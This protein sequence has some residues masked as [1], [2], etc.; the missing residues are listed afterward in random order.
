MRKRRIAAWTVGL[1]ALG[2]AMLIAT[3]LSEAVRDPVERSTSIALPGLPRQGAPYRIALLSDIHIGNRAMRP[4]RLERIVDQ[5]NAV[6]PDLVVLAGDFVNG[7]S[8]KLDSDPRALTAPLSRLR[9]SDGVI[10]TPGNHDHWTDLGKVTEA[11]RAAGITVLANEAVRRG[12]I[13]VLGIDD[14]YTGHSDVAATMAQARRLGGVPVAVTHSPDLAPQ[15]PADVP[16]L[17]AGHTHCGQIVLPVIGAVPPLLG[18]HVNDPRYLCG[19]RHEAGR[20]IVVTGGLGS[21]GV[22]VRI[23]APPDWWMISLGGK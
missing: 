15:L 19:I 17:L 5:V 14:H 9:A 16:L 20:E 6:R 13:T 21:G 2:S 18:Y 12:P 22:P 7:Q 11:L 23:G 8:G 4:E 1:G 3:G 10:A